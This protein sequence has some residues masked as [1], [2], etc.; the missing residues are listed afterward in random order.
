[1]FL[2]ICRKD[3]I[4]RGLENLDFILVTGEAYCDHP[5][6]GHAIVSRVI[7]AEGFT[8]GIISQ[9][10]KDEDYMIYGKPNI[11]F[12]VSS[13]VIDSMVNNY[14]VSKKRRNKDVY[15]PGGKPGLRPD[16]ATIVYSR[17]LKELYNDSYVM[18]GGVE[19]SLRRFAHYDYFKDAVMP[20]VLEDSKADL[21]MYGMGERPLWD[22]CTLLKKGVPVEKIKNIP[23]TCYLSKEKP[24]ENDNTVFLDSFEIVSKDKVAYAKSFLLQSEE[25]DD[26]YGKTIVQKQKEKY[27]VQNKPQKILTQKEMDKVYSLPYE[28]NYHPMYEKF[29]GVPA[30]TEVKFSL[31]SVRGCFGSCN[32]CAITYH[33]GRKIQT[34]SHENILEEA[35]ILTNLDDFKGYI[36]DVGGPT[37]NFRLKACKKQEKYGVCKNRL[38]LMPK[39]CPN[40]QVDHS[41]YLSLLRK[42]RK[43][44]GVKKVFVR[45]G[46]RFD[47][48][49]QDKDDTFFKE[50]CEHHISGQLKVA[51]EHCSEKVLRIMGKPSFNV[52]KSFIEK[53]KKI[54]KDLGKDQYVVPYFISSHPGCTL[55]DAIELAE[56]LRDIHHM[57]EQVQDFYPTPSTFSTTM[58][59]TGIDPR[60]MK[61]VYV[62][63]T[64]EEKQMQRAL[65]QYR[66][67]E[68]YDI[69]KKAL[70][71]AGRLD[72]IGFDSKCLIKPLKSE[73]NKFN[74]M[75]KKQEQ[76]KKMHKPKGKKVGSIARQR[77]KMKKKKK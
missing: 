1:M 73:V 62:P 17:K 65:L 34:R 22:I 12:L 71:K 38:C 63:K 18:I 49:M 44:D 42:L 10:Q 61:K 47:Y 43:V 15:S 77:A 23:G 45:S 60:T 74:D 25:Q 20:S 36:H 41:D 70:I 3:M 72:L 24:K 7:E 53:Y 48:L 69:V 64:F 21:L 26:I 56:Y 50:L 2:P 30:I 67:K 66:K 11:A 16:R 68:N 33:Q 9:P 39:P 57:P 29:G 52:Y 4:E 55:N 35:K 40:L 59:Y 5:S 51:P 54:N 75:R 13:G 58:Y 28:R 37:A 31:T 46:I 32:Y 27:L 76:E 8:I 19:A 14:T 6:F